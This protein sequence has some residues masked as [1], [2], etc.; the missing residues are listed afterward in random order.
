MTTVLFFG[1][2]QHYSTIVLEAL[3]RA[4]NIQ[5]LGVITSPPRPAGRHLK[6]T[7]TH[8]HD[9]AQQHNLP[10]F[11]PKTLG[12][13]EISPPLV[14]FIIVAGYGKLLPKDWLE[15]PKVAAINFH[16]SLLPQY[17]GPAPVEWALL[18]GEKITGISI[19]KMTEEYDQGPI[20]AQKKLPILPTDTRL[21]LYQKL[22][23]L[24][25]QM[26]VELIENWNIK[27]SLK[28]EKLKIENC[29]YARRL[30][31]IDGFIPWPQAQAALTGGQNAAQV[32]RKI[33]ALAGYPG[34]WTQLPTKTGHRR[35]KLLSLTQVQFEGKTP[36][37]F[38]PALV[39]S[40]S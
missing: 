24:G 13:L 28:I 16:P 23:E 5:V 3:H 19:I 35:L 26:V 32:D 40:L 14:D 39:S 1:S 30:H 31:R 17:P 6:L 27:N 34:V 4:Q 20:I 18:K 7:S 2:F 21:T 8:T 9:W 29:V 22:S 37:V 10:V 36:T 11:T 33:H 25:A 38:S 15:F 12:Q